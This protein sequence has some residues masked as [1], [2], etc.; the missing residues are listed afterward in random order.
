MA[1]PGPDRTPLAHA[2][3]TA[4]RRLGVGRTMLYELIKR[5]ELRAVKIGGRR[6]IPESELKRLLSEGAH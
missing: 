2:I 6:L 4:C 5:G 1:N 3:P